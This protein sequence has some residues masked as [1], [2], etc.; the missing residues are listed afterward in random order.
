MAEQLVCLES[1]RHKTSCPKDTERKNRDERKEKQKGR[2]FTWSESNLLGWVS[3]LL[4]GHEQKKRTSSQE[5]YLDYLGV[6]GEGRDLEQECVACKRNTPSQALTHRPQ[7]PRERWPTGTYPLGRGMFWESEAS[8]WWRG[9]DSLSANS[10]YTL[11]SKP[12]PCKAWVLFFHHWT[13]SRHLT[14]YILKLQRKSQ[15]KGRLPVQGSV[16][17]LTLLY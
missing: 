5:I 9:T 8:F 6:G 1:L 2:F 15:L 13:R 16:L 12:F 3:S 4:S 11:S 14:S 17:K 10:K 7:S